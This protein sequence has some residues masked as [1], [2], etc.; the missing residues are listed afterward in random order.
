MAKIITFLILLLVVSQNLVAETTTTK[1]VD[2]FAP[3]NILKFADYLY[4]NGDYI[5]AAGEYQ[6]YLYISPTKNIND[7]IYYKSTK[8]LFR[9]GDYDQSLYLMQNF[10]LKYP[11]S[12]YLNKATIG[13]AIIRYHQKNYHKAIAS[14]RKITARQSCRKQIIIGLSYLKLNKIDSAKFAIYHGDSSPDNSLPDYE[15][16]RENIKLL[17]DKITMAKSLPYKSP[18]KAGLLSAVIPGTGKIYCGRTSDGLY[19]LLLIGLSGWQAYDGFDSDGS[20]STKGWIFA[21]LSS[22]LYL[23]NI[24][25]SVVSAKIYNRRQYN[26]FLK[27]IEIEISLP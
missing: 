18:A 19:S 4:D 22:V 3:D 10:R 1:T 21:T 15:N 6:R 17:F 11:Q 24:Y 23:G 5:R 16:C 12:E 8:A 25:G 27:G 13:Q 14:A 2:Y 9:G 20:K 26:D 7:S